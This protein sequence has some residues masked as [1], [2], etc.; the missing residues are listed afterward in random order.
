MF[1]YVSNMTTHYGAADH[2]IKQSRGI[3]IELSYKP[4]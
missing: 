4:R 2:Y 3:E 1:N